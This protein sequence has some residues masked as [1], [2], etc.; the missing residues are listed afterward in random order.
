VALDQLARSSREGGY[1][2]DPR[3]PQS[4]LLYVS[5]LRDPKVGDT[6]YVFR[7]EDELIATLRIT[8]VS[9]GVRA[10][11]LQQSEPGKPVVAFDRILLA[12]AEETRG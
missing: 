7:K 3:D 8:A 2:L 12:S 1:I 11:L 4:I 6:V 9:D 5:R 10:S